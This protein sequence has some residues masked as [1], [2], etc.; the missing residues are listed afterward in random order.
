MEDRA[1]YRLWVHRSRKAERGYQHVR[2]PYVLS[3]S[4]PLS[5][6]SCW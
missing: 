3:K 5:G 6:Y 1:M 2:I 4:M